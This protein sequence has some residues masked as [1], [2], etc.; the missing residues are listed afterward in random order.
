[1]TQRMTILYILR[2]MA[3]EVRPYWPHLM[4]ILLLNLLAA[5]IALLAPVPLKIVIDNVAGSQSLPWYLAALAPEALQH[6]RQGLLVFAVGFLVVIALLSQ[7]RALAG[8][9]LETYAGE[10][11]VLDFR[12]KLFAHVQRLSLS[13]HDSKGAADSTFRIQYEA[14]ALQYVMVNGIIPLAAALSTLVGMIW[15]T[16]LL[17]AQLAFIALAVSPVLFL[18]SYRVGDRLRERWESVRSRETTANSIVQEVLSS[19]RVVKAFGQEEHERGRFYQES[20][21][22]MRALVKVAFLQGGFD[23]SVDITIALGTALTLYIGVLH[24]QRGMLTLGDLVLVVAY[25]AQIYSPLQAISKKLAD[26]QGSLV[27]AERAYRLLDQT[28]DVAEKIHA[29]PLLR[30]AGDVRF[31]NVCFSYGGSQSVLENVSLDA[32]AGTRVGIQGST[33]AGKT[34]LLSL[35]TRFYDVCGG[36]ILLDGVDIRDYKLADLRNQFGIVLQDS[37]LFS[38]SLA[39]NIAYGRRGASMEE[40]IAAAKLANAHDFISN[41]PEGYETL[42]GER[43]M[44]L[45]GGERQRIALARAF[46]KDAPILILDEPTSSVDVKTESSIIDAMDRLMQ[47]RTTFMIAHRLSTLDSCD[48]RLEITCN[49]LCTLQTVGGISQG[50]HAL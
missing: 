40:I 12:T 33:G 15:V 19:L 32:P 37:V 38:T 28:P 8:W 30:A 14:P 43:G 18:L 45:S 5:P 7:L 47:G 6:S 34:T 48:L 23:L 26:L 24:V 44:R 42:A 22:R 50:V 31:E 13:Y 20:A 3:K 41:L 1:M 49:T 2:R 29:R 11:M 10:G 39:E 35:L 46:L 36:R 27:G 17:D 16:S 4:A 21:R 9:V 25:I